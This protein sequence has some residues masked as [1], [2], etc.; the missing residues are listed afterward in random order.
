LLDSEKFYTD[1]SSLNNE[2]VNLQREL[3]KKNIELKKKNIELKASEDALRESQLLFAEVA[4]SS[5]CPGWINCAHGLTSP[6]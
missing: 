6:G 5:G 1:M 3:V 4:N 2:L